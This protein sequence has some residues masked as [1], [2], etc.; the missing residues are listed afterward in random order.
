MQSCRPLHGMRS[1]RCVCSGHGHVVE[2]L[3]LHASA[4]SSGMEM[5][6]LHSDLSLHA[7]QSFQS[8]KTLRKPSG[9]LTTYQGLFFRKTL[10]K[11]FKFDLGWHNRKK[12]L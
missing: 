4:A 7:K 11:E 6:V 5:M 2:L 8:N 12:T 1:C 9:V 10:K 3:R